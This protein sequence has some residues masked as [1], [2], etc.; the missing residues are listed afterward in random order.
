MEGLRWWL[1]L[2]TAIMFSMA[3]CAMQDR[4]AWSTD[5]AARQFYG[6]IVGA[7]APTVLVL[8]RDSR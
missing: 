2:L 8:E 5:Q 1:L 7:P 6:R 3:G 4:S